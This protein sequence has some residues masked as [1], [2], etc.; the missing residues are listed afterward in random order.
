[1]YKKYCIKVVTVALIVCCL[2]QALYAD[3]KVNADSSVSA[4]T[5]EQLTLVTNRKAESAIIWWSKDGDSSVA[6]FAASELQNYAK[7]ITGAVIPV[8]EGEVVHSEELGNLSSALVL[9][10]GDE[11]HQLAESGQAVKV[12]VDWL[13]S[14][15]EKLAGTKEDSFVAE[16][17]DNRLVLSGGNDR[18]T[19]YSVYELLE[20]L[21]VKFFAPAFDY[22]EGNAEYTPSSSSLAVTGM[23][24][25]SEPSFAFRRKYV[26]EGWSHTGDN[27]PQLIDWMAKNKL[28]TLVVPYDYIAQGKTKWDHWRER[29][30]T[31]LEK[32]GMIVEVG[33]HGFE[34]FLRKDKYVAAHPDWFITGYN[35]FNI[36]NDDAVNAYVQEV[37]N[38]LK[39]RPEIRIFDAWPPDVATWPPAVIAKF[40]NTA[41]AYAYVVNKL[42]EAVQTELPG[43]QIEAIAYATHS[44]TPSRE[45]KYDDSILIDFAPY[46]R[47][48]RETILD[49]N[50]GTNKPSIDLIEQWQNSFDGPLAMYEY[51]RRYAFHSLPV[52]F[53]RLIGEEI[54]FYHSLGMS[55]IGTFSEPA[56]WI[57]YEITHLI[58]AKLSWDAFLDAEQFIQDYSES[59]YGQASSELNEYFRL[60]E[61][62]GRTVYN[63]PTGDT[64][65]KN[66]MSKMR[67]NYYAARTHLASGLAKSANGG[68]AEYMM[69]RLMWNIEFAIADVEMDFYRL[70]GNNNNAAA[71]KQKAQ[72]L[73]NAHRFDGII[74]QNSYSVRRYINGFG[75]NEWMYDIY[76]GELKHAPMLTTMGT[77]ENYSI[78]Y[79]V[80][81]NL[82]TMY[83]SNASPLIGDYVGID[84][85]ALKR[86]KEI[87]L[88]MSSAEKPNDYIRNGV[89]E[90]SRDFKEWETV[91]SIS[92]QPEVRLTL[93]EGTEARFIRVRS[94]AAQTQ[95][96]QIREFAV[97][98]EEL[99]PPYEEP[100]TTLEVDKGLVTAGET[101]NITAGLRQI[102]VPAYAL[103]LKFEYDS[104]R[105]EFI[106]A[107]ALKDGLALVESRNSPGQVRLIAASEGAAHAIAGD[108][109]IVELSFKTK[110][111]A[112]SS[113]TAVLFKSVIGD[114]FGVETDA[115]ESLIQIT[116]N[117]ATIR[118][119]EDVNADGRVSIGD[120]GFVAAHYGK[121]SSHPDWGQ[122]K[123]A[124]INGDGYINLDDLVL[125]ALKIT[126]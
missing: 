70:E 7:K 48:Y 59:R 98:A 46:F 28:N 9:I 1:M 14:A 47:S 11:A 50:S 80:D 94:T 12:P 104:S 60:V 22:Y 15:N 17:S 92:N 85:Q 118:I 35:V 32:R 81:D 77:Y 68:A 29:L 61:E 13:T 56:D 23:N 91:A 52:V 90:I 126:E 99:P 79:I 20:N 5:G 18:G 3:P 57:T 76:R 6:S 115:K 63:S 64:N 67:D 69:E 119:P 124:D 106:S 113:E 10:E 74:L 72:D 30:I 120:L 19:L 44:Q 38:F 86:I 83:W 108:T 25:V 87:N 62:A 100:A 4:L 33:G 43:V 73:L 103:D 101:V 84:L 75:S 53:P 27:L 78:N 116:V 36:T 111:V 102:T 2:G 117:P 114:R 31:E 8:V 66:A 89:I 82:S 41:N 107:R 42:H 95:W 26:E 21:G 109:P 123:Q 93:E 54:P 49:S 24:S 88:F 65:N 58:L 16:M 112:E 51:Y 40:G 34:S 45:Y 121:D 39:A 55:G 37:V 125:V 105:L 96:I 122:I 97:E 71:A 110:D